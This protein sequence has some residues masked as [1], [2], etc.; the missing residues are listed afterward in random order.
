VVEDD[1]LIAQLLCEVLRMDGYE[2][3]ER[4]R[5]GGLAS[6][7]VRLHRPDLVVLDIGLPNVDGLQILDQLKGH[8]DTSHIPVLVVTALY[9]PEL[10][11]RVRSLGAAG[12]LAKPF[13]LWRLSEAV[14]AATGE[15]APIH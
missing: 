15:P 2:V 12:L 6:D 3:V 11:S 4:V 10:E 9:S 1:P 7:A 14:A 5:D 13:P 8:S